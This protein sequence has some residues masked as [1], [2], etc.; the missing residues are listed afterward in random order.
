MRRET[1]WTG[2]LATL[3]AA[4]LAAGGS[5][6]PS[7]ADSAEM[8]ADALPLAVWNDNQDPAGTLGPSGFDLELEIVESDWHLL[9]EDQP[10]GQVLAFAEQGQ[11]PSIP[12]PL[13]RVPLGTEIRV[14]I[15]NPLDTALVVHGLGARRDQVLE[16][17]R[18][19]PGSTK[20]VR[21]VADA[22]GTYFYWGAITDGPLGGRL[23]EDSQ[24]TGGLIVDAPDAAPLL[25]FPLV[26]V[27]ETMD[28]MIHPD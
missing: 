15:T 3:A 21:F 20:E 8:S 22:A 28:I 6:R 17:L 26:D 16:P 13:I 10:A 23:F 1:A 7:P 25:W 27:D 9:G 4:L 18:V 14:R 2:V 19:P 11:A 12:G 5:P 24:L